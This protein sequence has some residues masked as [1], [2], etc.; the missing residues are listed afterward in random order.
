MAWGFRY[1][2]I[3]AL[4]SFSAS[5]WLHHPLCGAFSQARCPCGHKRPNEMQL[6]TRAEEDHMFLGLLMSKETSQRP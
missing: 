1:S 6:C 3:K 2:V 5:F 4:P